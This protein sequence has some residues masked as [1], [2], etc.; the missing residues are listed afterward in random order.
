MKLLN[1]AKRFSP[2]IKGFNNT[3]ISSKWGENRGSYKHDGVDFA[4]PSGTP[5]YAIAD[6]VVVKVRPDEPR[7]GGIVKINHGDGFEAIFCHLKSFSVSN[8][9]TVKSGTLLGYSGGGADDPNKGSSRGAHLH[10]AMKKNGTTVNPLS[11]INK[12]S[13]EFN[14]ADIKNATQGTNTA[15]SKSG[16]ISVDSTGLS[17]DG[18][19]SVNSTGLSSDG[20]ISVDGTGLS[21]DGS[22][23]VKNTRLSTDGKIQYNENLNNEINRIKMLLT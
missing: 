8:N 21:S 7:C 20:S 10:F 23:S 6:G 14:Q 18:S 15:P 11:H 16:D 5:V 1:E 12:T 4:V 2:P 17:S 13:V 9:Q 19:I 22:I 3:R